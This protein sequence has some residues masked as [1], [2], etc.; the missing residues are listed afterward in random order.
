MTA[1]QSSPQS[2]ATWAKTGRLQTNVS[3]MT[4]S[5][6]QTK[7]DFIGAAARGVH[8]PYS[9]AAAT[10]PSKVKDTLWQLGICVLSLGLFAV[11]FLFVQASKHARQDSE[12]KR[13]LAGILRTNASL[14]LA[15]LRTAQ[16]VLSTITTLGLDNA[17][18]HIQWTL[19]NTPDGLTFSSLLALSPATGQ[20]GMLQLFFS[21]GALMSTR[22][23]TLLRYCF[24][25]LL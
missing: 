1:A 20:I 24:T 14:T 22:L 18:E 2:P 16:A 3:E 8:R 9:A 11:I 7:A 21:D 4:I 17:L 10:K 23:W 6:S 13:Q 19:M 12:Q 15:I 25:L 5:P